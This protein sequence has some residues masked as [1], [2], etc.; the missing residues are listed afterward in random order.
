[1]IESTL[2]YNRIGKL[3]SEPQHIPEQF[4]SR[5]EFWKGLLVMENDKAS[6]I[7]EFVDMQ[8]STPRQKDEL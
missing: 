5:V 2:I 3:T 8:E 1:M 7:N 6:F 4:T